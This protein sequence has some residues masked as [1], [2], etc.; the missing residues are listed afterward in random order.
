MALQVDNPKAA[1]IFVACGAGFALVVAML[2]VSPMII[3]T[4]HTHASHET[5]L[6][7]IGALDPVTNHHMIL[8]MSLDDSYST[9]MAKEVSSYCIFN[10]HC[11]LTS[12]IHVL[13]IIVP[14][15]PPSQYSTTYRRFCCGSKHILTGENAYLLRLLLIRLAF[16][17]KRCSTQLVERVALA[18]CERGMTDSVGNHKPCGFSGHTCETDA[19]AAKHT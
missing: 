15:G 10:A 1:A 12:C 6:V 3:N 2:R 16:S 14:S 13:T 11:G 19:T 7:Q 8:Q 17:L 5:R 9:D 18:Y 4:P